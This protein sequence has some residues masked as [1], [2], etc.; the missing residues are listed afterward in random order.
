MAP[1]RSSQECTLPRS[2]AIFFTAALVLAGCRSKSGPTGGTNGP[3]ERC[4]A[5]SD[6]QS[7]LCVLPDA[8]TPIGFCSAPCKAQGDCAKDFPEGCCIPTQ[9]GDAVCA[10]AL[11]CSHGDAGLGEPCPTQSECANGLVCLSNSDNTV[12]MCSHTCATTADC[13]GVA[14]ECCE[15]LSGGVGNPQLFCILDPN[16]TSSGDGGGGFDAGPI[17]P[18]GDDGGPFYAA[19]FVNGQLTGDTTSFEGFV[20]QGTDT[21]KAPQS[22]RN[23][24]LDLAWSLPVGSYGCDAGFGP[25]GGLYA[26][27]NT[28]TSAPSPGFVD[29]L[30]ASWQHLTI[31]FGCGP[32]TALGNDALGVQAANVDI[33]QFTPGRL[34]TPDAGPLKGHVKGSAYWKVAP[35]DGGAGTLEVRERFDVD[36]LAP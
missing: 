16:C 33:E 23:V 21:L 17:G 18:G 4:T 25:D 13:E 28:D 32:G 34:R 30:P 22:A 24:E 36:L 35:L 20:A 1:G 11:L 27:I 14:Q 2:L 7:G 15:D 12:S 19:L 5:H 29:L 31:G 6:C 3:G 8:N 26:V 10:I 9:Q